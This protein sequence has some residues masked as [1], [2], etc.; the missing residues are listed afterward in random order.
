MV[1]HLMT[2]WLS[3]IILSGNLQNSVYRCLLGPRSKSKLRAEL[4]LNGIAVKGGVCGERGTEGAERYK[5][6]SKG[7]W[8]TEEEREKRYQTRKNKVLILTNYNSG[9]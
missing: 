3:N 1:I 8:R 2:V 7:V 6:P 5:E 9:H 4:S